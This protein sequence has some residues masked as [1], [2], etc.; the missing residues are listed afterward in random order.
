MKYKINL[1]QAY[2]LI[3]VSIMMMI[4]G[5]II[6]GLLESS[7]LIRKFKLSNAKALT[8]S[9]PVMG[10]TDLSLWL[11]TTSEK[12]FSEA[13]PEDGSL[14]TRWNDLNTQRVISNTVFQYTD[15]NK[16]IYT[17]RSMN[18]LPALK[19]SGGQSLTAS[20]QG[21]NLF[22]AEQLTIFIVQY[23][24][25]SGSATASTL[26]WNDTNPVNISAT[27][28][29]SI[30]FDTGDITTN[31][32]SYV[33]DSSFYSTSKILSFILRANDY[34]D[35]KINGGTAVASST[36]LTAK[37]AVTNT[38][39]LI[40]GSNLTGYI[41]EIIVYSRAL[42]DAERAAIEEYLLQKWVV[43]GSTRG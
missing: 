11:E 40:I 22:Q 28:S 25:A 33:V 18:S 35:I 2:S 12:S 6:S 31:R 14:V 3:E 9:S 16:P 7:I 29:G 13:E 15:A 42:K 5:V 20:V 39:N 23:V 36:T 19:F 30:Y 8:Q 21:E 24:T 17:E 32:V 10:I 27:Q 34:G 1:K 37:I 43:I 41:G 26:L 4:I 38:N